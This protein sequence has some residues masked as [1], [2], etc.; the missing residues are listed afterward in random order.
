VTSVLGATWF[1]PRG[2]SAH[3]ARGLTDRLIGAGWDA[4][5]VSG[6]RTDAG[7]EADAR[8]FYAG[9]PLHA[10]DFTA[11]L[12]HSDPLRFDP[13]PGGAPMHA[14]FEERSDVP[15]RPLAQLDDATAALHVRAW[16]RELR[17]AGAA[18]ADVLHLHHLT[19][20]NEAAA[21]AAPGVPVVGHLHGTELLMLEAIEEGPP[22]G[23][24][25]AREWTSRL[26]RWASRCTYLAAATEGGAARAREL[27]PVSPERIVVVPNG[28][29]EELFQARSVDRL[30][31]WRKHLVQDPQGARRA[32][33]PGSLR[34]AERDLAAFAEGPVLL[35]VGRFTAVKRLPLL[36]RA[37]AR[38]RPR[39]AVRAPLVLLGGHPG[40]WE[41]KHPLDVV[42][43]LE[44]PDVFLAGWHPHQALPDFFAASD[45]LVLPSVREQ[46]GLAIVEAMACEVAPIAVDRFGPAEIV[47]PGRTGWL[48]PPDDEQALADAIV[49]AVNRPGERARRARRAHAAAHDRWSWSA[50]AETLG[51]LLEE[52]IS[53]AEPE[54]MPI[55]LT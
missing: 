7:T 32:G 17:R 3:A 24:T 20:L 27:L 42:E 21:L 33:E 45:A 8:R 49:E 40:E 44:V 10:V 37:Y 35:Y 53:S 26:G 2:G 38:A 16:A 50:S 22:P 41:G 30:E 51:E 6:S 23:W 11:A 1:F 47:E 36:I 12:G 34:Y 28:F 48:V 25:H 55:A 4:R 9:L 54:R 31:H 46:F 15:D 29:D 14:S 52:A 43:A 19:P 13:G 18:E 5:L 39:L